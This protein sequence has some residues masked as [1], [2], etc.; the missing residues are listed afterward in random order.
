MPFAAS[1]MKLD[2]IILNDKSEK[3]RQIPYNIT[4]MWNLKYDTNEPVYKT[5]TDSQ[6][7]RTKLWS[8]G[9]REV[10][11]D[12]LGVWGWQMQ[13]IMF[14]MDKQQYPIEYYIA[15]ETISNLLG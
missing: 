6:T 11:R 8:P 13:T 12:G 3:E 1:W 5:V 14:R 15:Q 2:I 9:Q 4:Y 7:Q 10:G